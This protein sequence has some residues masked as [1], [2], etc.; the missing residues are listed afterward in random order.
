MVKVAR[1][2]LAAW[3]SLLLLVVSVARIAVH[4]LESVAVVRDGRL[5]D[6]ELLELCRSGV[7]RG[8]EKM[9]EACLKAQRDRASPLVLKAT[10]RAISVAWA[11]FY[12]TVSTPFGFVSVSFFFLCSLL[13]PTL[14]WL[15]AFLS[16]WKMEEHE[17]DE[18]DEERHVI[19]LAGANGTASGRG[20]VRKRLRGLLKGRSGRGEC[21]IVEMDDSGF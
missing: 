16:A 15:R 8:S 6:E 11:E 20:G 3:A 17:S 19:V 5:A 1:R 13:L 10:V 7:A 18:E 14:P 4:F 12:E 21:S 2:R 9:R